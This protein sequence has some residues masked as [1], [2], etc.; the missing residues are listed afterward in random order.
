MQSP[1][2]KKPEQHSRQQVK[3]VQIDSGLAEAAKKTAKTVKGVEDSAAVV[4]NQEISTAIKVTGFDRLRLQSI[5]EEVHKKIE[6]TNKDYE[7]YVTSDK[8]LFNELQKIEKQINA[9]PEQVLPAIQKKV[10]KINKDM[11]G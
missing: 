9:N 10:N 7:V 3:Q 2:Q 4:V 11:Q 8:K 6:S 1:A 5:K